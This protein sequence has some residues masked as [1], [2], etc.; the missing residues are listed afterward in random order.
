[1][2]LRRHKPRLTVLTLFVTVGDPAITAEV[3]PSFCSASLDMGNGQRAQLIA[4]GDSE[5][6]LPALIERTVR[7][8]C[9]RA[10]TRGIEIPAEAY[11]YMLGRLEDG[12]R[13]LAGAR[14]TAR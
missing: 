11:V 12:S 7:E 3:E 9:R 6:N 14:A 1:M 10:E 8:A 13:Y 5:G 4:H 2:P